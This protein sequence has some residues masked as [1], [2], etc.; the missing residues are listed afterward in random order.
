[1]TTLWLRM[2]N[3]TVLISLNCTYCI[4]RLLLLSRVQSSD[5]ASGAGKIPYIKHGTRHLI[6]SPLCISSTENVV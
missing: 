6:R 2:K 3:T 1:V 4:E 5:L